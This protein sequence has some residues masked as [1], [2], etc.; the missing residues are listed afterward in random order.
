MS[1]EGGDNRLSSLRTP[2]PHYAS[3]HTH[4]H[5]LMS[6]CVTALLKAACR[7]ASCEKGL[8]CPKLGSRAFVRHCKKTSRRDRGIE[9]TDRRGGAIGSAGP[10]PQRR[11]PF[12]KT[13]HQQAVNGEGARAPRRPPQRAPPPPDRRASSPSRPRGGL[14]PSSG[15]GAVVEAS[16]LD[17]GRATKING[18]RGPR[19]NRTWANFAT[20]QRLLVAEKGEE[21][22]DFR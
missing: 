17:G 6:A 10:D 1:R 21:N 2:V 7:I 8:S 12:S 13:S 15:R 22:R 19:E 4:T 5:N 14:A 11:R 3:P 20:G 16:K 9:A 18:R